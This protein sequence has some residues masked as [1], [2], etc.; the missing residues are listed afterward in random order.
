LIELAKGG[1]PQLSGMDKPLGAPP[2]PRL[3]REGGDFDFPIETA[4]KSGNSSR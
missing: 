1:T 3:V 4:L 2:F